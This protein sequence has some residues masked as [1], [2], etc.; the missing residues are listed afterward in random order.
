MEA[1]GIMCSNIHLGML[2]RY[3]FT[4]ASTDGRKRIGSKVHCY[5]LHLY[6]LVISR[7]R[8]REVVSCRIRGL[9]RFRYA[10]S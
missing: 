3:G 8:Y 10:S 4:E 5:S 9:R 6:M 1:W 2:D 7:S